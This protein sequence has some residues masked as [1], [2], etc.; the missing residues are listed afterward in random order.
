MAAPRRRSSPVRTESGLQAG[1]SAP[2]PRVT[3]HPPDAGRDTVA[4]HD[5]LPSHNCGA[6]RRPSSNRLACNTCTSMR[7]GALNLR[8]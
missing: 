8:D 3:G 5:G 6:G 4:D 1:S 7:H 2:P